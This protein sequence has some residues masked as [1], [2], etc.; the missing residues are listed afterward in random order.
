MESRALLTFFG[1]RL[2]M[3]SV[4]IVDT[5]DITH[6]VTQLLLQ[7]LPTT[8]TASA[9][10][11]NPDGQ[12]RAVCSEPDTNLEQAVVAQLEAREQAA[13][14]LWDMT[15]SEEAASI[16]VQHAAL[17]ILPKVVIEALSQNQPRLAELLAGALANIVCHRTLAEQVSQTHPA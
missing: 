7:I 12:P 5:V 13:C 10:C 15:S 11:C 3:G 17:K 16:A 6:L 4:R 2:D 8:A 14:H 9:C 1:H